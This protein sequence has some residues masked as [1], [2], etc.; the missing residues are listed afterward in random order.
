MASTYDVIIAGAGPIGL[1]LAC[2][3][4]M[5]GTSVLIL[6]R[7]TSPDSP[8]KSAPLGLRGLNT[9]SLESLYRRDIMHL[10]TKSERPKFFTPKAGYTFGGHFA[11]MLLN[12]E[13]LDMKKHKYRLN[14]PALC[15]NGTI[16][17]TFE[18]VL[19]ERAESLGVKILRGKGVTALTQDDNSVT[20]EAG[21]ETFTGKWLV[22][23]DGGRSTVRKIGGFEF[24]G[25]KPECTG[26]A[27]L[28]DLENRGSLKLG[29][30]PSQGGMSIIGHAGNLFL[31]DFDGGAYDRMKE[32]TPEHINTVIAR[33]TGTEAKITTLK[34]ASSFT[35]RSMQVTQYRR[36][37]V[38]LAGDAAHIHSPLGAQGLNL[39]LGDAMNLG[40]KLS[41][42]VK[43]GTTDF[44]LV[45]SYEKERLPIGAWVLEWTRA[46]VSTLRPDLYGKALRKIISDLIQTTDGNNLFMDRV[47]GLSMRYEL[48]DEHPLVGSSVPDFELVDGDRL[49]PRL[50]SGKGLLL[51]FG[52]D[53][54]LEGLVGKYAGEVDYLSTSAKEQLGLSAMLV[55]P[56]GVVAWAAEGNTDVDAAK[57][58][59]ERWFGKGAE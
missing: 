16:L 59:F 36:G 31:L 8:F 2:E 19:T 53:E 10:V 39:G 33:V 37:R 52:A 21:G 42:T 20:V 29:F 40:W 5:R 3:L 30:N 51:D 4:G 25:T 50:K 43:S 49:G 1:F 48:G 27:V 38:L 14:G 47:W 54:R 57:A 11:G 32:I 45:D 22:G 13:L 15:P 34:Y 28:G 41:A 17:E 24:V 56:D 26:Y 46:Q 18:K 55:R 7:D 6:E 35:D 12:A 58:A 23:C 9:I 44:A